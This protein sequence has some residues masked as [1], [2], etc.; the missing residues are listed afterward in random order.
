MF[1]RIS[2]R[3]ATVNEDENAVPINL[4]SSFR[5]SNTETPKKGSLILCMISFKQKRK[6][7]EAS[8]EISGFK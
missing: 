2:C 7:K 8:A 6:I 5:G 1:S 3:I 4:E